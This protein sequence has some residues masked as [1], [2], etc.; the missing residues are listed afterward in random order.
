MSQRWAEECRGQWVPV[1]MERSPGVTELILRDAASVILGAQYWGAE[2][3]PR[4]KFAT[5]IV[6]ATPV[7]RWRRFLLKLAGVL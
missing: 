6:I 1:H 3:Q 5:V 7:S 4:P 2:L